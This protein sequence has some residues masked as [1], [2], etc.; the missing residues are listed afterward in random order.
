MAI[1]LDESPGGARLESSV[2]PRLADIG[3][4]TG[5]LAVVVNGS[6]SSSPTVH[7][8]AEIK[9]QGLS[10]F[11]SH[12][13]QLCTHRQ[14]SSYRVC[15]SS[16]PTVHTQAEIKLQGLS[17]IVPN[18]ACTLQEIKLQGLSVIVPNC[19]HTGRNQVTGFVSHRPQL[20]THRQKSSY[21]VCQSSSPTVHTQAE[22][23]LQG[24][25]VIVPNCAC[26]LQEI[27]L[28]GV[29]T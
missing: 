17:V 16:S 26:T 15:Q 4:G 24:L 11:V 2:S 12:R 18:C 19:A 5:S 28:Q 23:K 13:P 1:M 3:N 27:K 8:Q 22:I 10:G 21:R 14:K 6:Q 20:C 7:T 9:L 25:S 29:S